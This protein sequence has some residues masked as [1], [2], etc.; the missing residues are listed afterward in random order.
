MQSEET[1]FSY[2]I[3]EAVDDGILFDLKQMDK[4][5]NNCSKGLFSHITSNLLFSKGY[6]KD[7]EEMNLPN[8]LDLLNQCLNIVRK[9]TEGYHGDDFYSGMIEL[10]SGDK[11]KVFIQ[12]NELNK[13]T[14]MLPEDY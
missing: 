7:E 12:L 1:V 6:M 14:V 9:G 13:F 10:P 2:S 5:I 8:F 4:L 3:N 11:Q